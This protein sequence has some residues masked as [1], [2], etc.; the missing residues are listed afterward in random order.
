MPRLGTPRE[1]HLEH[2]DSSSRVAL[3]TGASSGIGRALAVQLGR[4]HYR[5]AL[6]ARRRDRLMEA[7]REAERGGGEALIAPADVT[8]RAQIEAVVGM[9]LQRWGRL[10]VL[11]NNAGSGVFGSVEECLP[12]DFEH[13]MEVNYLAVV[14][15]VKAVLP[16]MRRQNRGVIIN[17]SSISGKATSPYDAAY[18]ASKFALSAF[19]SVLRMELAGTKI[20]VCLVSP[21]YTRTEWNAAVVQRR[22]YAVRTPLHPMPPEQVAIAIVDCAERPRREM[23][24]PRILVLPVWLQALLPGLYE[25]LQ[26]R[27][28]M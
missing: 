14:Y 7:A 19:T 6:V 11:V 3:I 27:Y 16:L 23:L 13:Q 17:V 26:T 28:R 21:G 9:V 10:D 18:C 20:S 5:V 24:I 4:K 2:D 15:A 1:D 22:P 8:D 25:R 12:E